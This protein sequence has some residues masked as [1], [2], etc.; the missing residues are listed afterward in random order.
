MKKLTFEERKDETGD[1]KMFNKTKLI[2]ENIT[3][4][5]KIT[6]IKLEASKQ[7]YL[8]HANDYANGFNSGVL[9]I[10]KLCMEQP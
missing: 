8:S 5:E 1:V 9:M 10:F 4:E 6:A 3:E 2:K 7:A